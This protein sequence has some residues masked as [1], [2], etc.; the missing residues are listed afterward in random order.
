[1]VALNHQFDYMLIH[2]YRLGS[3]YYS[4]NSI[5]NETILHSTCDYVRLKLLLIR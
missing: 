5:V 3:G 1:M 4:K 2:L